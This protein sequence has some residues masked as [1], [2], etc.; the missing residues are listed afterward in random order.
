MVIMD[1]SFN[2]MNEQQAIGRAYRI[3]QQKDVFVYRLLVAGSFEEQM[4]NQGVHKLHL[5]QRVVDK[6][7]PVRVAMQTMG[8]YVNP[9]QTRDTQSKSTLEAFAEK[10][11]HVLQ[12]AIQYQENL[13]TIQWI[14]EAESFSVEE[15]EELTADEAAEAL[16]EAK[17][18]Q[19]R[20]ENPELYN[21]QQ[22]E[23]QQQ[24]FRALQQ[25]APTGPLQ[26][27]SSHLTYEGANP[28][29]PQTQPSNV[30]HGLP[31]VQAHLPQLQRT[32][33]LH[34]QH[35]SAPRVTELSTKQHQSVP[36]VT[37]TST[38][39]AS[40]EP[41]SPPNLRLTNVPRA[42]RDS[43]IIELSK[44]LK[45]TEATLGTIPKIAGQGSIA[46]PAKQA[47]SN[48]YQRAESDADYV[49]SISHEIEKVQDRLRQG[50]HRQ[51][52]TV[53]KDPTTN[54]KFSSINL[55]DDM[56]KPRSLSPKDLSDNQRNT[57]GRDG[58]MQAVN[59]IRKE[60]DKTNTATLARNDIDIKNERPPNSRISKHQ[61]PIFKAGFRAAQAT[62]KT[63]LGVISLLSSEEDED[64]AP[65][66]MAVPKISVRKSRSP[67][68]GGLSFQ[69][70]SSKKRSHISS[71]E[72]ESP[73][74]A[75]QK[76]KF[77]TKKDTKV[78]KRDVFAPLA[79]K[80][81]KNGAAPTAPMVAKKGPKAT[82]LATPSSATAQQ[83][84][85]TPNFGDFMGLRD[86]YK[87]GINQPALNAKKGD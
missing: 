27:S 61:T 49:L 31:S 80:N 1:D 38:Q 73:P 8:Q 82:G 3:G 30:H 42:L 65:A 84:Q 14:V 81:D 78:P 4:Q 19:L 41:S 28:W 33:P 70:P 13:F 74:D 62:N 5:A 45:I 21:Q 58:R 55:D 32:E 20:R 29:L 75:A 72:D 36:R 35:E 56:S 9:L 54:P 6:E 71:S 64:E 67:V 52:R 77:K 48:D 25:P 66:T 44:A 23:E 46:Q 43:K 47:E 26:T 39:Q 17:K 53:L 79:R 22:R 10:D 83:K 50:S 11:P 40:I 24:A 85:K 68:P 16:K 15:K 37:D 76:Q 86:A 34:Q 63:N 87:L 69:L 18:R 60:G 12:K 51:A 7:E 57:T 2:P 59:E